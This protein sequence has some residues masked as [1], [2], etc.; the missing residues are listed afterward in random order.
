VTTTWNFNEELSGS[1]ADVRDDTEVRQPAVPPTDEALTA[2]ADTAP[3]T[4]VAIM[5]GLGAGT[6]DAILAEGLVPPPDAPGLHC[7]VGYLSEPA[8]SYTAE[9]KAAL[10][11]ELGKL[12]PEGTAEAFSMAMFNPDS[13]EREPCAV[14]LVQSDWLADMHTRVE[15]AILAAGLQPSTTFPIW[16]PHVALGY[17]VGLEVV[18]T[19]LMGEQ[20]DF[21]RLVLGWA[22][23]Q[24]VVAGDGAEPPPPDGAVQDEAEQLTAATEAPVTAPTDTPTA[25]A[26]GPEVAQ[27]GDTPAAAAPNLEP[28]GQTWSGVIAELGTPSSDGRII[29]GAGLVVRP[30][31]LPLSW[32]KSYSHGSLDSN[33]EVVT[34]GRCLAVEVRGAQLWASGDYYDPMVCY[35]AEQAMAQVDASMGLVSV[36]LAVL[37]EGFA[38]ELGNP[39]DPATMRGDEVVNMVAL[40]SE[41]GGVTIVPFPAF[42]TARIANDPLT[43]TETQTEILLMPE[44]PGTFAAANPEAPVIADDG[45]SVTLNDGTTVMVGDVVGIPDYDGDGDDEHGTIVSIDPAAASV[46]VTPAVDD[47]GV[48][49]PDQTFPITD[50]RPVGTPPAT[51]QATAAVESLLASSEVRPYTSAFFAQR[52]LAGPTP[53][54]VVPET[55]EVYGHLATWGEC[56]VGKLA[57]Q[58]RCV[59]A[60]H[61]QTG[62]AD[63]HLTP[64][65]TDEGPL[66][67]GKITVGTGH[68]M[69]GGG[70]ANAVAHYDNSGS[71]VAVV[72]AYEDDYGVQVTGQIIHDTPPAKIEELMR[73]PLSGDWRMRHLP[74]GP[75]LELCAA[76]AVTVPGFPVRRGPVVG[77]RPSVGQLSLVAA[78]VVEPR[79][80]TARQLEHIGLPSG[81]TISRGDLEALTAAMVDA[82]RHKES[83]QVLSD[84]Q[85]LAFARARLR[86]APGARTPVSA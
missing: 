19:W 82:M 59:T 32:Q 16:I 3:N 12:A 57:E 86:L 53:L 14:V 35:D 39:I 46:T 74:T 66:D 68:A 85:R 9:Q 8:A 45:S 23:E 84:A 5:L 52:D 67:I 51:D 62:Y 20:V 50:L 60:P 2:A 73:S 40:E 58:G 4:G 42:A 11:T 6:E 72:R 22:G 56:H 76:L 47:D 38:D 80:G 49:D 54:T 83:P 18:P 17:N 64:I 37:A 69:P 27:G 36:D 63:F 81:A 13:D 25:A 71:Q 78:G 43:A 24:I 65:L 75:N 30:L 21:N 15:A 26:T 1:F 61:S 48:Q 79:R 31:P 28:I 44:V 29:N 10:Q 70:F 34:V 41:F 33:D 55:G 7:T 77:M